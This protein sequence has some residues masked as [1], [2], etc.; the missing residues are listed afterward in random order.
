MEI[1][2]SDS[3]ALFWVCLILLSGIYK[4]GEYWYVYCIIKVSSFKGKIKIRDYFRGMIL[5][6]I[7]GWGFSFGWF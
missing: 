7:S 1:D 6:W 3:F 4:N 5:N 2:S